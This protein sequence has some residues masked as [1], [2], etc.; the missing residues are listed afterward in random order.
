MANSETISIGACN[1]TTNM[2]YLH[3][4]FKRVAS[5]M[6]DDDTSVTSAVTGVDVTVPT[7]IQMTNL[8]DIT[9][10]LNSTNHSITSLVNGDASIV[11]L[12]GNID[13][14]LLMPVHTISSIN[15]SDISLPCDLN[16]RKI[17]ANLNANEIDFKVSNEL[18][19]FRSAQEVINNESTA[20]IFPID[21]RSTN[22]S[23]IG[24]S[25]TIS[26]SMASANGEN[27]CPFCQLNCS[28]RSVLIK[29]IR[30]HTNER[31]YPCAVCK[32][33]FKTKTNLHKHFK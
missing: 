4:K 23:S 27:V 19:R 24:G 11:T 21:E 13:C 17:S 26:A 14:Q 30:S 29:H 16:K 7:P 12:N 2:K 9:T 10:K 20:K 18:N 1:D 5:A 3:K 15:N 32:T 31:P 25:T 8:N 6:V 33:A 22:S 28:K